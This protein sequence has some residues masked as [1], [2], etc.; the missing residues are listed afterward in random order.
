[1]ELVILEHFLAY[2]VGQ[3]VCCSNLLYSQAVHCELL[4]NNITHL[5]LIPL[6]D[7]FICSL[8]KV[9]KYISKCHLKVVLNAYLLGLTEN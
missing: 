8:H 2:L 7:I 6:L 4:M 3:F 5:Y 9:L 1:L